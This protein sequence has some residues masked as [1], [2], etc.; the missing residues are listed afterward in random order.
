MGDVVPQTQDIHTHV[1]W[2]FAAKF[3]FISTES[4]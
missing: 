1:D 2:M 4:G 3:D